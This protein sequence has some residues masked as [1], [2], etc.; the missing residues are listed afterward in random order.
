MTVQ[1]YRPGTN[2]VVI[3]CDQL[4][5]MAEYAE[6]KGRRRKAARLRKKAAS[7]YEGIG[8]LVCAI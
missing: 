6:R 1:R 8:G 4:E 2:P 3:E 5:A 7:L